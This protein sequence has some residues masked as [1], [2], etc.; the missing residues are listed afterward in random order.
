MQIELSDS[1]S[2]TLEQLIVQI[3]DLAGSQGLGEVEQ[4]TESALAI[5]E[6][7]KVR[8]YKA[9]KQADQVHIPEQT[10]MR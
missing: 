10:E 7:A 8:T 1:E 9:A 2:E 3:A 6:R 4:L 5:L